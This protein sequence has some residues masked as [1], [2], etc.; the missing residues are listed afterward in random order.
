MMRAT[1]NVRERGSRRPDVLRSCTVVCPLLQAHD[2]L[3]VSRL[4]CREV[5]Q[6]LLQSPK[7]VSIGSWRSLHSRALVDEASHRTRGGQLDRGSKR[8]LIR[9]IQRDGFERLKGSV[10]G[11]GNFPSTTTGPQ[12]PMALLLHSLDVFKA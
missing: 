3:R 9:E 7:V 6:S 5:G 8:A 11:R 10:G 1:K 12:W 2:A 4:R